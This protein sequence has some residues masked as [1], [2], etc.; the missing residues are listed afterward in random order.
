ME[1]ATNDEMGVCGGAPT[2]LIINYLPQSM[3]QDELYRI[4]NNVG[5]VETCKL[6]RDKLTGMSL[7]YGFVN[8]SNAADAERAIGSLNGLRLQSKTIKVSYARPSSELIRDTN[9]YVTGLPKSFTQKE[10][11]ELFGRFGHIITSRILVDQ[12]TGV[13]RGVAF[14]RFDKRGEAEAA[15]QAL[16]GSPPPGHREPLSVRLASAPNRKASPALLAQLSQAPLRRYPPGP[17]HH[18]AQ[19]FRFSPMAIEGLAGAFGNPGYNQHGGWSIF[20]YNLG[21]EADER[22]LWQLFGP[23]GA[24]TNVKVIRDFATSK[25]KGFGFVTMPHH[26]EAGQAVAALNGYRLGERVLQVSFK[27]SKGH[28]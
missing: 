19:K 13:S 18:H 28:K 27:T 25:C 9:L 21:Q 8:F 14:I 1:G 16:N 6:V 10:L 12:I 22:V 24:V 7:G 26:E 4:F 20:V 3:S 5:T 17:V 15:I 2:N 23:F 11:E